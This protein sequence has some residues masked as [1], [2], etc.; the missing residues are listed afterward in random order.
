MIWCVRTRWQQENFSL[1]LGACV[2]LPSP[3]TCYVSKYILYVYINRHRSE[4]L[5]PIAFRRLNRDIRS[6]NCV[7]A[8]RVMEASKQR[9]RWRQER[10]NTTRGRKSPENCTKNVPAPGGPIRIMRTLSEEA[11]SPPDC[12]CSRRFTRSSRLVTTSCSR[13]NSLSMTP[14][15]ACCQKNY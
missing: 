5:I 2:P 1:I 11:A 13:L 7:D 9:R 14:M 12:R 4:L 8:P 6:R 3:R 15:F 10:R